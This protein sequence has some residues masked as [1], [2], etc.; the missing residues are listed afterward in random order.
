M[1]IRDRGGKRSPGGVPLPAFLAPSGR[2]TGEW[3]SPSAQTARR[4][5]SG[6]ALNLSCSNGALKWSA[7]R[8]AP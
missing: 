8:A 6:F 7:A 5:L 2:K 1:C 3:T 4:W